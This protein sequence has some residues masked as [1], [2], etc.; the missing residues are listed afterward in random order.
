MLFSV[1]LLLLAIITFLIF[2]LTV[3]HFSTKGRKY[4]QQK[5][6]AYREP[7]PIFGNFGPIFTMRKSYA[8]MLHYF[9]D[10]YRNEKYVGIF[11]ARRPTL[12]VLDL[13]IVKN[14]FSR[15]FSNFSDRVSAV[16]DTQR[17]PLLRNLANM[18]GAEWKAMRHIV[19]P[20]FSSAKMKAMFPLIA[21][22]A[23]TLKNVLLDECSEEIDIPKLMCRYTTD[24]IGSCAFG[25]DPGSLKNPDS[26]FLK[27]S[28]KMFRADRSTILKRYCRVFFPRLFKVLNLRSYSSDV[29]AF[30]TLIIKQVLS[31]R[32]KTGIVRHDFLQLML[33]VQKDDST[34]VMTDELITSNSFIFML[35]GLETSATTLSFCLYELAKDEDLQ[36][37]IRKEIMEC[38]AN[39][40]TFNY[41]SVCA[42]RLTTQAVIETLRLHPPTPMTTRLCTAPCTLGD[43]DLKIKLK[44]PL[45]I[46]ICCIQRDPQYFPN[47]NKFDPDR[48][49]NDLNPPTF[50]AFGDGPRSCPGGRFAQL[51]V[52]AGLATMLS[53]FTVEPCSRTTSNIQYDPRSVMLKNKGGIWLTFK[54]L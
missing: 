23:N 37:R 31:E 12:M 34:F 20:T 19:S 38:L 32:R 45:L 26:P 36:D 41:D 4:W 24:V 17:E 44:D 54:P 7:C 27:M 14:V 3:F 29:E 51:M 5:N 33:N 10:K 13:D 40:G 28:S 48:F 52:V 1:T 18:S 11:Q 2:L 49:E 9:Y 46:P 43:S 16:T 22:C 42:M 50:L 53:T 6:V 35:A 47:P 39:Y 21:E 15:D 8:S 30:F 25:V